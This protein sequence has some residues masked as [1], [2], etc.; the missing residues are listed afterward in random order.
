M[1][2]GTFQA[3][4]RRKKTKT[5]ISK[6]TER[7]SE[8]EPSSSASSS[9]APISSPESERRDFNVT[10]IARTQAQAEDFLCGMNQNMNAA[11]VGTGLSFY[12][13]DLATMRRMSERRRKLDA[14]CRTFSQEDWT[15]PVDNDAGLTS[16]RFELSPSGVQRKSIRLNIHVATGI[17]SEPGQYDALWLLADGTSLLPERSQGDPYTLRLR[18]ILHAAPRWNSENPRPICLILTQFEGTGEKNGP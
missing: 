11:A 9:D 18:E 6:D 12:I 13:P 17:V 5:P 4:L 1:P 2:F 15:F 8:A 10:L 7:R 3:A 16:F 14:F